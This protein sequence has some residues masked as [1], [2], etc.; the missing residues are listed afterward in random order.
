MLKR[1]Y[2]KSLTHITEELFT[3]IHRRRVSSPLTLY[4]VRQSHLS[5]KYIHWNSPFHWKYFL[6]MSFSLSIKSQNWVE[7]K[8]EGQRNL[9]ISYPYSS[10]LPTCCPT[11]HK[12]LRNSRLPSQT[13]I[14]PSVT[15]WWLT[16]LILFNVTILIRNRTQ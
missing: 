16:K 5:V 10:R 4:F 13:Y 8:K 9:L 2:D 1:D 14:T 12:I 7:W 11:R 15:L 6:L 3:Q